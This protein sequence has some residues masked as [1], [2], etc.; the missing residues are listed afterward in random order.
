MNMEFAKGKK[1]MEFAIQLIAWAIILSA[2]IFLRPP[3]DVP[4]RATTFFMIVPSLFLAAFYFGNYYLFIPQILFR[5]RIVAYVLVVFACTV[6]IVFIPELMEKFSSGYFPSVPS[7]I[8]ELGRLSSTVFFLLTLVISSSIAV[9]KELFVTWDKNQRAEAEKVEAE[10]ASLRLQVN[11]HFLFNTL[12]NIYYLSANKS[13]KAPVAIL[14]LSDMM[15]FIMTDSQ[16]KHIPLQKEIEYIQQYIDLQKMRISE[17]TSVRFEIIGD[18]TSRQ[19]A[20]LILFPFV[21]NAFKYGVSSHEE[22]TIY[23]GLLV[24]DAMIQFEVTNQKFQSVDEVGRN[25][26]G[27]KNVTNRL[28]LIYPNLHILEIGNEKKRFNVH[29]RIFSSEEHSVYN[30][31]N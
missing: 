27:L 20:P 26:I 7:A 2:P 8:R 15:R 22:T 11:P 29:L 6:T 18:S 28:Q 30:F 23:I 10:L 24:S 12:Y 1:R 19:I 13:D 4:A 9:I 5:K 25:N 16:E 14:K 3:V 31:F 21:E 17:K